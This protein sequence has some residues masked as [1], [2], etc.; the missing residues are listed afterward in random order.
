MNYWIHEL[1]PKNGTILLEADG[2]PLLIVGTHGEGRVA[3]FTG[4][5][6]GEPLAEQT[7]FWN[8]EQWP[9]L[10][11]NIV[12]WSAGNLDKQQEDQE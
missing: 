10:L 6:L 12:E 7:P 3:V 2:R 4:S 5:P 11:H 8:W 9:Q 1:R